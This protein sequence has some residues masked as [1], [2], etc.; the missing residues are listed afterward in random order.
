[1]GTEGDSMSNLPQAP[2]PPPSMFWFCVNCRCEGPA[3]FPRET[4][5][6]S[7]VTHLRESHDKA[8]PN[9]SGTTR[10]LRILD[11]D[12]LQKLKWRLQSK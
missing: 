11:R 4:T 9:C 3:D 7:A 1:M 8:S 2:A 10:R 6:L 12:S 5:V